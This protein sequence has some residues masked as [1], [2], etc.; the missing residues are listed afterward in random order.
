MG[1]L[2]GLCL[3]EIFF[4]NPWWGFLPILSFLVGLVFGREPRGMKAASRRIHMGTPDR[5]LSSSRVRSSKKRMFPSGQMT[6]FGPP[7][8]RVRLVRLA[9][10]T[11]E[12]EESPAIEGIEEHPP[13]PG[14]EYSIRTDRGT[15][16]R[17]SPVIRVQ[18]GKIKTQHS[19]YRVERLDEQ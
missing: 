10:E 6:L 9:D 8:S 3:R 4:G 11:T 16:F 7:R 12:L 18:D 14:K 5:V 19:V 1:L 2:T 17:T 13:V 15:L